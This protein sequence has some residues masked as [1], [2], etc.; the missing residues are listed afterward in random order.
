MK[1]AFL[2]QQ[3]VI[4]GKSWMEI[5][6]LRIKL[7]L[8]TALLLALSGCAN[9]SPEMVNISLAPASYSIQVP[10]EIA[11]HL[12]VEDMSLDVSNE[13]TAQ[14]RTAGAVAQVMINYTADDGSVHG[15]AGVYY[16]G[17]ADFDKA[18][19]PNEPPLYGSKV[20]EE[21]EMVLAIAGPQDSIFDPESQDGKNSMALYEL[22]YDPK[23]F[24]SS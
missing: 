23:S 3:H 20:I 19:N 7:L 11:K 9:S 16:F 17:K 24:K 13:F 10:S 6:L 5:K 8:T 18:Q 12:S 4:L 22:I 15:F 14:A 1:S 2:N 21:N